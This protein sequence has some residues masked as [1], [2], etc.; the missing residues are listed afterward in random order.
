[1][2][3]RGPFVSNPPIPQKYTGEAADVSPALNWSQEKAPAGTKTFALIC[4]DPDAPSPKRP[5]AE[6]WVHWVLY[7]IPSTLAA[8]PEAI[9]REAQPKQ[10]A[11][12]KQG[13][14]S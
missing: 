2:Q 12:A 5:A 14:N 6:P 1:M 3:L 13:K 8:L 7:N 10:V 4:D 11:G 9:S